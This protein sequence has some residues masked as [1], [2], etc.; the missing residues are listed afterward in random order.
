MLPWA[1]GRFKLASVLAVV[2]RSGEAGRLALNENHGS[3]TG[4]STR[5]SMEA[6]LAKFAQCCIYI[7]FLRKTE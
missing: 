5:S 3:G 1:R 2:N 7:I 6:A 4:V